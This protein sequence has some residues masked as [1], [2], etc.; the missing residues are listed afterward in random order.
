LEFRSFS[1]GV[2]IADGC[3]IL[4]PLAMKISWMGKK[5]CW[6]CWRRVKR[7]RVD[8]IEKARKYGE[9]VVGMVRGAVLSPC[10]ATVS[11]F[12][13]TARAASENLVAVSGS[14]V[15]P[16]FTRYQAT[17]ESNQAAPTSMPIQELLS[18]A[19]GQQC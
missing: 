1:C 18:L 7:S 15:A 14:P 17:A 5:V 13:R 8:V 16:G 19:P 3:G 10:K 9:V 6:N 12:L 11:S 2:A 4:L